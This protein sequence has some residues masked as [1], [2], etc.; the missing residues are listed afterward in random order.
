MYVERMVD[1][2]L[3][4]PCSN[5]RSN[6]ADVRIPR[7][8]F[9]MPSNAGHNWNETQLKVETLFWQSNFPVGKPTCIGYEVRTNMQVKMLSL[10]GLSHTTKISALTRILNI[11]AI[12]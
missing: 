12:G 8:V 4:S 6:Y 7:T 3:K 9:H 11:N 2:F 5:Q 1:T 10:D